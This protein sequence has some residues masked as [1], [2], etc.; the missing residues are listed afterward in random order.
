MNKLRSHRANTHQPG[1]A[2]LS[3][4]DRIQFLKI[5]EKEIQVSIFAGVPVPELL[6]RICGALD[7]E[8]GNVVSFVSVFDDETRDSGAL[9]EK[10]KRFG[11]HMFSSVE[12]VSVNRGLLGQLEMYSSELRSPTDREL[13]TIKRG[14]WLA[15]IAIDSAQVPPETEEMPNLERHSARAAI[16]DCSETVH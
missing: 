13:D 4:S 16:W 8:I 3:D 1:G 9:A 11:L 15:A 12:I 6:N 10:A 14:A 7:C 2:G 5:A